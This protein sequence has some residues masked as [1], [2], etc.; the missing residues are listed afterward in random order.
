M[1]WLLL[2]GAVLLSGCNTDKLAKLEK[3]NKEL[4]AKLETASKKMSLDLQENCARGAREEFSSEHW[5]SDAG[6]T[7]H[8]NGKLN[9]CFME[10]RWLEA[11]K[12]GPYPGQ[13]AHRSLEKK[14]FGR[15]DYKLG[16]LTP[17]ECKVTLPSGEEVKC[18]SSDEYE[19]L[20][21]Q[22]MEQ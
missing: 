19:T 21:K 7:N 4:T 22:Y 13:Y 15:F 10:T 1:S 20:I 17:L 9:R 14:D 3:E 5:V 8:Y 11:R 12:A 18:N 2:F 6:F 16:E